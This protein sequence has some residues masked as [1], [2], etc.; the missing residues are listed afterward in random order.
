MHTSKGVFTDKGKVMNFLIE[1]AFVILLSEGRI[2]EKLQ[3]KNETR[4]STKTT[5]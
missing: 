5:R 4:S 3:Q 2:G 1:L